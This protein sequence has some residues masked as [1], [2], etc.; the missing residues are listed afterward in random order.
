MPVGDILEIRL[1]GDFS[2]SYGGRPVTAVNTARLQSLLAYLVLHSAGVGAPNDW[3]GDASGPAAEDNPAGT[4]SAIS[5]PVEF[6]PWLAAAD[7]AVV[8]VPFV[9]R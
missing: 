7:S 1:L 2:L 5:G 6:R 9:V 8:F 3:W 4:G